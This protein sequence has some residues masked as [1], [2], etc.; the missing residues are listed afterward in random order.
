[1]GLDNL[2]AMVLMTAFL[3]RDQDPEFAV[4]PR[5]G[6]I[7]SVKIGSGRELS[8]RDQGPQAVLLVEDIAMINSLRDAISNAFQ[9]LA[10]A[11]ASTEI[12]F[13]KSDKQL[14]DTAV[15]ELESLIAALQDP[16]RAARRQNNPAGGTL[17]RV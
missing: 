16:G 12:G 15:V 3:R 17:T 8:L 9:D 2:I 6:T 13:E 7:E 10:T 11:A 1:M 5:S 14:E 4:D